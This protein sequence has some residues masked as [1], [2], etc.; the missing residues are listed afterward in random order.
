MKKM[1]QLNKAL[2]EKRCVKVIS[3]IN[4][5]D[6]EKVKRVVTAADQAGASAVDVAARENIIYITKELTDISVFV[7]SV[8]P[9]ELKMAY[10]NGADVLEVGNFDNLYAQGMSITSREVL[11]ITRKTLDLVGSGAMMSV[12]VPGHLS[13]AEQIKDRKSVV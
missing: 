8:V 7:S 1:E 2:S 11:D 9:E 6:T 13:T 12:T 4:N 3:G 10:D 5:F